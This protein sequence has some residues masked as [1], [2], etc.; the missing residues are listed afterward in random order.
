LVWAWHD[1]TRGKATDSIELEPQHDSPERELSAEKR[2]CENAKDRRNRI[3]RSHQTGHAF[4]SIADLRWLY[5]ELALRGALRSS[6]DTES[7]L[8]EFIQAP[9][10]E[11]IYYRDRGASSC[12]ELMKQAGRYIDRPLFHCTALRDF[13]IVRLTESL[14]MHIH[15][16]IKDRLVILFRGLLTAFLIVLALALYLFIS[17]ESAAVIAALLVIKSW[18]WFRQIDHMQTCKIR[19]Q[20]T[21]DKINKLVSILKRGGFDEPTI[22]R[23]LEILDYSKSPLPRL[24]HIYGCPYLLGSNQTNEGIQEHTI[25]VPDVLYALLRLPRRNVQNEILAR[26][27]AL[28]ERER[29]D[30]ARQWRKFVDPMLSYDE[31]QVKGG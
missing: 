31:P 7:E 23:Q 21:R 24:V 1:R 30:L 2:E 28:D 17:S 6:Y 16:P 9:I 18:S 11:S 14:L 13:F 4:E 10:W 29:D 27:L 15:D 19:N 20:L 8:K 12:D 26:V 22:T 25:P 3:E 5:F